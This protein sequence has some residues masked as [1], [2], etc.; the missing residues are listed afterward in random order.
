[1]RVLRMYDT[2]CVFE[3]TETSN[4]LVISQV[5]I[6]GGVAVRDYKVCTPSEIPEDTSGTPPQ[7]IPL[8]AIFGIYDL[9]SGSYLALIVESAPVIS[10]K[11]I[12]LRKATKIAV[13]PLFKQGRPLSDEA[14]RDEDRYLELLHEGFSSHQFYFSFHHDVT[15]S[16]QRHAK[17]T[18]QQLQA[19]VW[20][21]AD[22]RFFWNRDVVGDLIA[23]MADEWIVP[24][25]S[26]Y[27]EVRPNVSVS[28]VGG[29]GVGMTHVSENVD[30]DMFT[31]LFISRR[32]RNRQGCRFTRRGIDED[33]NVANFAETEQSLLFPNGAIKSM[34]QIRGSIPLYW[35]SPVHMKYAPRVHIDGDMSK[36]AKACSRHVNEL[37][38]LYGDNTPSASS[39]SSPTSSSPS[40]DTAVIFVNLIDQKKEQGM[41]GNAFKQVL[42]SVKTDPSANSSVGQSLRYVWFDFHHECRKMKYENLSKLI[43]LVDTDFTKQGFFYRKADGKVAQFQRGVVRTNCMDNLDRTNV[44]QSIFARRSILMQLGKTSELSSGK[45]LNTPYPAFEKV[46]KDVWGNNAD[47]ISMLYAGTGA[48]KTDFTRTGKRTMI[49]G[50]LADGVNSVMR[51]YLNNLVDGQRQDSVDLIIGKYKPDPHKPSPFSSTYVP[52]TGKSPKKLKRQTP[53]GLMMRAFVLFVAMFAV[54]LA[55]VKDEAI[56]A[57]AAAAVAT[58]SASTTTSIFAS[59]AFGSKLGLSASLM[60]LSVWGAVQIAFVITLAVTAFVV[61]KMVAKGSPV[62]ESLVVMPNLIPV[63]TQPDRRALAGKK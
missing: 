22:L 51:Y 3:N 24:V 38:S 49:Q 1:M 20:T 58:P 4:C 62:G 2:K 63:D 30:G 55:F 31:I 10:T 37:L 52:S 40:V 23:T 7:V 53:A 60:V 28:P 47:A 54:L 16:F 57:A 41:L 33:G 5:G 8:D 44:V 9:L 61:Y 14:Q 39:A 50:P 17:L 46:F 56:A 45:V 13:I 21:R 25:M 29:G 48:L 27:V 34:V 12:D 42:D 19:P 35:A 15:H 11:Y 43:D 6:Q 59:L 36:S 26:A 18:A 32:S